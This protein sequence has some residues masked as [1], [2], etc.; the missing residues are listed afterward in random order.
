VS[1]TAL[2]TN[3]TWSRELNPRT[4]T[5]LGIGYGQ[6]SF[7]A[8]ANTEETLLTANAGLSYQLNP[9][10]TGSVNYNHLN[11]MSPQAQFRLLSNIISVGIRKE[12]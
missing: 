1:Q 9:T 10:L 11:R 8:P 3:L 6:F 4:T 5:T 2:Q 12:F 7:A